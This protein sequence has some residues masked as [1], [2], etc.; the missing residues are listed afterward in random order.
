MGKASLVCG[1]TLPGT[2]ME[3]WL[4]QPRVLSQAIVILTLIGEGF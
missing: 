1:N 2:E 4:K 3:Q